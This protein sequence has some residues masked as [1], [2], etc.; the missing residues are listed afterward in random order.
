VPWSPLHPAP[1]SLTPSATLWARRAVPLPAPG[2]PDGAENPSP[3]GAVPG[4]IV[5]VAG[6]D[7]DG[8]P[9][10]IRAVAAEHAGCRTLAPPE[11]TVDATV[12]LI[13]DAGLAH[14][15]CHGRFRTDSPL[16]SALELSDGRLT[17]YEMLSR[18]VA[19][20]RVVLASC[21]SGTQQPYDGDEVLGFVGAMMSSG[22]AGLVAAELPVPDGACAD[23]MTVLHG[24]IRRGDPLATAVWHAR[25]A[26]A[27]G[28]PA[29]FVAWCGLAAYGPA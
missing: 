10:E 13:R 17:L 8:A 1:V 4:R 29:E 28:G 22:T 12:E 27:G 18:G 23:A 26:L 15:A 7:L 25:A 20:H 2:P 19:P 9:A 21:H 11:S 5:A 16:F 6:P 14:L 3:S 24:R